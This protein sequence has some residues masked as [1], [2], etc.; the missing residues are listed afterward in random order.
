MR[1]RPPVVGESHRRGIRMV[2]RT[3]ARSAAS[4]SL[5]SR[6]FCNDLLGSRRGET[7][8]INRRSVSHWPS[9]PKKQNGWEWI[10]HILRKAH[11]VKL[12]SK[13]LYG[14]AIAFFIFEFSLRL[15]LLNS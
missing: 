7:F 10:G 15:N 2:C 6:L 13:N 8:Q 14:N 5:E 4:N 9:C 11:Q 1:L 3:S 12:V